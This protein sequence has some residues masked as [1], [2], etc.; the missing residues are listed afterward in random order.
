MDLQE[1]KTYLLDLIYGNKYLQI[2]YNSDI[3]TNFIIRNGFWAP[4]IDKSIARKEYFDNIENN[5]FTFCY[6]GAGNF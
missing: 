6:R 3:K 4:G 1:N 5:L 2:L